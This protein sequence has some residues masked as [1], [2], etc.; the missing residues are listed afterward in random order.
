LDFPNSKASVTPSVTMLAMNYR[1]GR[2][3]AL[4]IAFLVAG[5]AS[6]VA[7]N[8]GLPPLLFSGIVGLI[9]YVVLLGVVKATC[10]P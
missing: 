6:A 10:P 2:F 7:R 9:V 3:I 4:L 1:A 5:G 8:N